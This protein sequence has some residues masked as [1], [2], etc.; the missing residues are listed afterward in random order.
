MTA[1]VKPAGNYAIFISGGMQYRAASGEKL[2]ISKLEGNPGDI[3][4]VDEVLLITKEGSPALIG[5]PKISGASVSLKILGSKL[6]KKVDIFKKKRRT[7][8]TKRQGHRQEH[9]QVSVEEITAP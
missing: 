8:Y 2:L 4:K 9:T 3:V 5:T 6:D 7:G 1:E